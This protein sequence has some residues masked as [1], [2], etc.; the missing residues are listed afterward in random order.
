MKP[1]RTIIAVGDLHGGTATLLRLLEA[2]KPD[3]LLCV[4]DWGDAGQIAPETWQEI[5]RRV[6]V[7]TVFGNH[8]DLPLLASLRNADDTPVLLRQGERRTFCGLSVAGVS[9]IWAKSHRLPH[10]VTDEDVAEWGRVVHASQDG[11]AAASESENAL[12]ILLTHG[13]PLGI[14]YRTPS[15]RPGGQRCFRDLLTVVRPKI[16]LC[17]HLHVPQRQ[18]LNDPPCI[19]INTG[20]FPQGTHPYVVLEDAN[21]DAAPLAVSLERFSE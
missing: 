9:G 8:D 17:G 20:A 16:H 12:D 21:W 4:G 11:L 19:V 7:L 5:L 3:G 14:A 6:P 18:D 1:K 15:G 10:Y 13:C 2:R